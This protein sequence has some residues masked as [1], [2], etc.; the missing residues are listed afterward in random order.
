MLRERLLT[1]PTAVATFIQGL[2]TFLEDCTKVPI[3]CI[4]LMS[5]VRSAQQW[6]V[7]LPAASCCCCYCCSLA[8]V[9]GEMQGKPTPPNLQICSHADVQDLC[10]SRG[11]CCCRR[12]T[13]A[14]RGP[15]CWTCTSAFESA[16]AG[17][18]PSRQTGMCAYP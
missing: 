2:H 4:F 14:R 6:H 9:A 15:A 3:L 17:F 12:A 1:E 8:P 11:G 10:C 18:Q 16:L 7:D 13:A 5:C